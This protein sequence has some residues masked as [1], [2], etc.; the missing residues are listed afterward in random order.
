MHQSGLASKKQ[1]M[2]AK[3]GVA[4]GMRSTS[5]PALDPTP[6]T[7]KLEPTALA[8]VGRCRRGGLGFCCGL[9]LRAKKGLGSRACRL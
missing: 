7:Q 1:D 8:S 2:R 5:N 6:S 3:E 9:G 4:S